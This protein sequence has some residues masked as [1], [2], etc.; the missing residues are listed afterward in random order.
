MLESIEDI[1]V[2]VR[3]TILIVFISLRL[4]KNLLFPLIMSIPILL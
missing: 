2:Y 4:E 1:E 3:Y